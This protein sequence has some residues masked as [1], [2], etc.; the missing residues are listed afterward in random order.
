MQLNYKTFGQGEPLIILHGLFGTLDNWQ[1]LAKRWAD[2]YTV[3]LVDQRN[4]G[5]SPH[6]NEHN[7]LAMAEDLNTFMEDNWI[8]Q[9]HILG[10]SMGGKTAMQF[11]VLYPE[12]LDK[13]VVIDIAPKIYPGGHE[14]ILEALNDL[15]VAHLEDRKAADA[16]LKERIALFGIRQF[17]LKNLTREKTGG[18]RWKMNLPALTQ[19]YQAILQNIEATE[20][21]E[22]EVLFVKGETSPYIKE[23]DLPLIQT[24]FP[25]AQLKTIEKAGHW[26][27]AEQPDAL[28]EVVSQF[29]AKNTSV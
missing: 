29:L 15:D 8:H 9:A 25:H 16:Q 4:H 14:Q 23:E 5:R 13:L 2:K 12:M 20:V 24:Y 21:F 22:G 17:L 10:H 18:Y 3:F 7:Y 28:F 6:V 11:A 27:H 19:N 1:T 26:V